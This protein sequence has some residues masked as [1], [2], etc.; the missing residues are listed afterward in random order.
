MK[1]LDTN[2]TKYVENLYEENYKTDF[3]NKK[4]NGKI[5]YVHG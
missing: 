2:L 3:K 4:I 1:Y 5:V